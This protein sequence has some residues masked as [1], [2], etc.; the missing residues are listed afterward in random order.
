MGKVLLFT[1]TSTVNPT[2]SAVTTVMLLLE[3]GENA[4]GPGAPDIGG[5][6]MFA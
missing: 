2:L 5:T 3:P 1:L 4:G 6:V